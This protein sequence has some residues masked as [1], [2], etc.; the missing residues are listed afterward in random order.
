MSNK[1]KNV[2][3]AVAFVVMPIFVS[4]CNDVVTVVT[5]TVTTIDKEAG[6]NHTCTAAV[7]GGQCDN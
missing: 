2:V 7:F 3:V 4:G 5:D 6:K 1:I